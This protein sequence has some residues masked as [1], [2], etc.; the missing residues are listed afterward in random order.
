[1]SDRVVPEAAIAP[2]VADGPKR[3]WGGNAAE[4]NRRLVADWEAH[5]ERLEAQRGKAVSHR[6]TEAALKRYTEEAR[7]QWADWADNAPGPAL[8]AQATVSEAV[9]YEAVPLKV[10]SPDEIQAFLE[11]LGPPWSQP[12]VP[13][14]PEAL[15]PP[16]QDP[17]APPV[18]RIKHR[19]GRPYTYD[20]VKVEVALEA[21]I[22]LQGFPHAGH[23]DPKWRTPAEVYSFVRATFNRPDGGPEDSTLRR[24]VL[25]M[26]ARIRAKGQP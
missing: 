9:E 19:G 6:L 21:K 22:K 15:A 17:D 20:W 10:R 2:P 8:R 26:L 1:M 13:A 7:K 12:A 14:A 16:D 11:R 24:R 23:S 18:P 25:P 3:A 5:R 4:R